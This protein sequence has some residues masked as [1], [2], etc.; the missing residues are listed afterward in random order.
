MADYVCY[1]FVQFI[2]LR[3]GQLSLAVGELYG[4]GNSI[5]ITNECGK[6]QD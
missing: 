3:F 6:W 5:V 1:L 2:D 4:L